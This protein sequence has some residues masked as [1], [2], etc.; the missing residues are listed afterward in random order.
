MDRRRLAQVERIH[1]L[2]EEIL[3]A[4]AD[5]PLDAIIYQLEIDFQI[6]VDFIARARKQRGYFFRALVEV[7]L[8]IRVL[9]P[10]R[11]QPI[12]Q[13]LRVY[14]RLLRGVAH[15]EHQTFRARKR[16]GLRR[17]NE[18][19]FFRPHLG[20]VILI[21]LVS[22]QRQ[23]IF[24]AQMRI[25]AAPAEPLDHKMLPTIFRN[26]LESEVVIGC[27]A[28]EVEHRIRDLLFFALRL[29]SETLK[30]A[31]RIRR[32]FARA[33]V[34][35][36][37]FHHALVAQQRRRQRFFQ[38]ALKTLQDFF[39]HLR[40]ERDGERQ[41]VI[42]TDVAV[43]IVDVQAK[44]IRVNLDRVEVAVAELAI[45]LELDEFLFFQVAKL[46]PPPL[47]VR[48]LLELVEQRIIR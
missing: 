13:L 43:H 16:F 41:N 32:R 11:T 24:A 42:Q 18:R 1:H 2:R 12:R 6:D 10:N 40:V 26:A 21:Q 34:H 45:G 29:Q 46:Q 5:R 17:Q 9:L 37:I 47:I 22:H 4:R 19:D 38:P 3:H 27:A 14:L 39:A 20:N 36:K 35:S 25:A 30:R 44:I 48:P 23:N 7:L 31:D 8:I 28:A 33:R 15:F